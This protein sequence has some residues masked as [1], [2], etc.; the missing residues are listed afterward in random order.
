KL[1]KYIIIPACLLFIITSCEEHEMPR[2]AN[3]SDYNFASLDEDGGSWKPVLLT[4]PEQISIAPPGET[5]SPSYQEELADVKS[6]MQNM[7]DSERKAVAYWTNNPII[8]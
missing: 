8:R 2:Y 1:I 5:A 7:G 3:Y 6:V 4:G